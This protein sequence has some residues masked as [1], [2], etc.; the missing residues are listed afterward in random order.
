MPCK[1]EIEKPFLYLSIM[2][3]SEKNRGVG[4]LVGSSGLQSAPESG[5]KK[6]PDFPISIQLEDNPLRKKHSR[7]LCN[8]RFKNDLPEVRADGLLSQ[9]V[10]AGLHFA[11]DST[12]FCIIVSL[13]RVPVQIPSDPKMLLPSLDLESMGKFKLFSIEKEMKKDVKFPS[14]MNLPLS[15]LCI[16]DYDVFSGS[17]LSTKDAELLNQSGDTIV[18]AEN[19][20]QKGPTRQNFSDA[21]WLMRTKYISNESAAVVTKKSHVS[22]DVEEGGLSVEEQA[23]KIEE[24]FMAVKGDPIHPKNRDLK[25]VSV[26]PVLPDI[27]LAS[28]KF[29]LANFD[30]DPASEM[31][32]D[33]AGHGRKYL[34]SLHLKTLIKHD[35][36]G[37]AEKITV[38]LAPKEPQDNLG[39]ENG[40][41]A[42]TGEQLYG[43]YDWVR[44]YD[45][46][47][48]ID[49]KGQTFLFRTDAGKIM[50]SDLN[51]RLYLRK[52][53][54]V[55]TM[56]DVDELESLKPE[57]FILVKES[58]EN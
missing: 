37:K 28:W 53:K 6:I 40:G 36:G 1:S 22:G 7:F 24:S 41:N 42:I 16:D 33:S 49:E 57:K 54:R 52:R 56:D 51:T 48:R 3:G 32:V 14:N 5:L 39:E 55:A 46:N 27:G 4:S 38:L 18:H 43:D 25:P 12:C 19:G 47:V 29:V 13:G 23:N 20:I 26:M 9:S 2:V 44:V 17:K 8:I 50:Y 10:S 45:S 21:P 30:Y 15:A 11:I 35:G 31:K 58:P 34:Q